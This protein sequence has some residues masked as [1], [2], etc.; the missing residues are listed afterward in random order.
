MARMTAAAILFPFLVLLAAS[1]MAHAGGRSGA[2]RV[3]SQADVGR[4]FVFEPVEVVARRPAPRS[5]R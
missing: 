5:H 2:L 4:H 1:H 3:A